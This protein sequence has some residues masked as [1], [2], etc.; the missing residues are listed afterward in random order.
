MQ[1]QTVHAAVKAVRPVD[2]ASVLSIYERAKQVAEAQGMTDFGF[3]RLLP[4]YSPDQYL[5]QAAGHN[6][7]AW[8]DRDQFIAVLVEGVAE[9]E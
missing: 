8:S 5:P 4:R 6:V 1:L 9:K 3:K 7:W 2:W